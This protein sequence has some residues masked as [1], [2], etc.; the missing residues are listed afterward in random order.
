MA[1]QIRLEV[2]DTPD[3]E[4][5]EAGPDFKRWLTNT[6]DIINA[7]FDAINIVIGNQVTSAIIDIG[8]SG[9]GPLFV[10]VPGLT[11]ANA[12][13]VNLTSSTNPVTV[14]NVTTVTDGFNVTFSGN[15]GASAIIVYQ[16]FTN[17]NP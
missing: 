4:Q 6:V 9:A 14:V 3:V 12:V 10:S 16:A 7:S 2:L 15:P 8:G 13:I 5:V 11:P 17:T 1:N